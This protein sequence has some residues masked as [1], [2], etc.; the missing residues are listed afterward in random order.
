MFSQASLLIS[1]L[2]VFVGGVLGGFVRWCFMT[3]IDHPLAATLTANLTASAIMGFT[4]ALPGQWQTFAGIGFAGSLSTL[5]MLAR[6]LGQLIDQHE[7]AIAGIYGVGTA[8]LA[9]CAAAIGIHWALLGFG[10]A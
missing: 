7:Y 1:A 5:A 9:V 6:Q 10:I 4:L 3:A 8:L 2:A